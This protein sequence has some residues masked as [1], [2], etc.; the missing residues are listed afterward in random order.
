MN[1]KRSS[2]SSIAKKYK[3]FVDLRK[4]LESQ[5]FISNRTEAPYCTKNSKRSSRVSTKSHE[6]CWKRKMMD[7]ISIESCC[8]SVGSKCKDIFCMLLTIC[9]SLRERVHSF[10]WMNEGPSKLLNYEKIIICIWWSFAFMVLHERAKLQ[11]VFFGK[12]FFCIA[13]VSF[14]LTWCTNQNVCLFQILGSI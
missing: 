5:L 3:E 11:K 10:A 14:L 12:S 1:N 7:F 13:R 4:K 2:R 9:P 6:S 8:K